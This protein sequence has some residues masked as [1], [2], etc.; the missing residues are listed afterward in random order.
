MPAAYESDGAAHVLSPAA[1]DSWWLLFQD[2]TLNDLEAEAF[3]HSPDIRTV[4]ARIQEARATRAAQ[5]AQTLPAGGLNATASHQRSYAVGGNGSDISAFAG[6]TDTVSANSNVS[7]EIDL[8]GRLA[9]QRRVARATSEEARFNTEGA[10]ATLAADVAD[11][12]FQARGFA[13][14]LSD[15]EETTRIQRDLFNVASK[16]AAAGAGPDDEVDR[17]AGQL[18]QAESHAA[19]L[20]AKLED[21]RRLLLILVGRNLT[22]LA[23][24]SLEASEPQIPTAPQTLPS[25]LLARRPDVRESEY[26]LRAELGTATLAH[27]AIFPTLTILPGL[28]FSSTA[29]PGVSYIPPSTL[30]TSQQIFTTGF[31]SLAGG[32][33]VPVLDIPKLLDQAHAEDA[34]ARQAAIAYEKTVRTAF[35]EAQN[36]LTDLAAGEK[37]TKLL[38]AGEGRA[39][40]AYDGSRRRYAEGLDDLTATLTAE[41]AWRQIRSDLTAERVLTLRRAVDTYKALGGG[42]DAAGR[43]AIG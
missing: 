31:W 9:A 27:R 19:D 24:L 21:E 28:G 29:S 12:Y 40:V 43:G 37:A 26:R 8:F 38:S 20:K 14:Q 39:H 30:V 16:R 2:P 34:R 6:V 25:A 42:W 11:A 13:I 7:W 35:G 18:A 32:L 23:N 5:I 4:A 10:R 3:N 33:S 15:A 1:L 36:A 17:V 41:Q 22:D